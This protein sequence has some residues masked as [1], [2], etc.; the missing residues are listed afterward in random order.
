MWHALKRIAR[1]GFIGFVRNAFVSL[2]AIFVMVVTLFVIGG[3]LFVGQLLDVSL[4]QIQQKVDVNVYF[5]TDATEEDILTFRDSLAALPEVRDVAYTSRQEALERF[6]ERHEGNEVIIQGL[7]ELNE[8]PLGASLSIRANDTS[9]YESI[10][11]FIEAERASRGPSE[12]FIDRVNF[13]QNKEAI[14]KLTSVITAVERFSV[15]A[16]IVL[17]VASVLITFNTIRLAIYTSREEISV[18]RLVGAG[19]MF[20]RGPFVFQ[21]ILYG[22][23]A[24]FVTLLIFYPLTFSLASFTENFFFFNIFDYYVGNFPIIFLIIAGAGVALGALSSLLAITRYL[25]N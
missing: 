17:L 14:D 10:A 16:M 5:V 1:S 7:E 19:N 9:Q 18:M 23:V 21:G 13:F 4:E 15:G 24:A 22:L 20:I 2:A 6:R 11:A 8:N 25:R 3:S 12:A